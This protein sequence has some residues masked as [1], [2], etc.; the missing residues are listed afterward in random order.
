MFQNADDPYGMLLR[1]IRGTTYSTT[2]DR[3][4]RIKALSATSGLGAIAGYIASRKSRAVPSQVIGRS[5]RPA[6]ALDDDPAVR[7][8]FH[9]TDAERIVQAMVAAAAASGDGAEHGYE[10]VL[11][12]LQDSGSTPEELTFAQ[13]NMVHPATA[14]GLAR[15]VRT[16]EMAVEIYAAALLATKASTPES[17][18]FLAQ[19]AAAL[20]LDAEFVRQLHAIWDDPPPQTAV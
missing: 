16:H 5:A 1:D 11:H 3:V 12:Y 2:A 14:D 15:G 19:L 6:A 7:V 13:R 20:P 17:R 8:Q 4:D 10:H 18:A 9:A